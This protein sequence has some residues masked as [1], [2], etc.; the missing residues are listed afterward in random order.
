MKVNEAAEGLQPLRSRVAEL[1]AALHP[2]VHPMLSHSGVAINGQ[3]WHQAR[4]TDEQMRAARA[5]LATTLPGVT[6]ASAP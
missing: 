1:E 4:V 5:A 2:F 6:I 3:R